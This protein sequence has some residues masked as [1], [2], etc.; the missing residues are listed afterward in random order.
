MTCLQRF[1]LVERV[2][3][4]SCDD[5]DV[6]LV[7]A[8]DQAGSCGAPRVLIH[9][10]ILDEYVGGTRVKQELRRKLVLSAE[11][12]PGAVVVGQ[13]R[14]ALG[15][16]DWRLIERQAAAEHPLIGVVIVRSDRSTPRIAEILGR[17]RQDGA[18]GTHDREG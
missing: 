1:G 9:A 5:V 17:R 15:I 16:A 10:R 13:A 6:A 18:R 2:G 12:N 3:Y 4:L 8:A 7:R 14:R 11:G